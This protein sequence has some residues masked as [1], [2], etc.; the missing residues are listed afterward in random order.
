MQISNIHMKLETTPSDAYLFTLKINDINATYT[1][2]KKEYATK[3]NL[4]K[5]SLD[6][7]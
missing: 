4:E 5:Y 6:M 7:N 1:E 2:A 3:T